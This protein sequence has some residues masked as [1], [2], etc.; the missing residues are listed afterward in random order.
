MGYLGINLN[1]YF[2]LVTVTKF[3]YIV[4]FLVW[5]LSIE[6]LVKEKF[7]GVVSSRRKEHLMG[8]IRP[9]NPVEGF[10]SRCA[11]MTMVYNSI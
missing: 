9:T 8:R 7:I 3:S 11:S 10:L 2:T 5:T 4:G 1:G 6:H